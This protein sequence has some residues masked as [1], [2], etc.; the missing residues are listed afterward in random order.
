MKPLNDTTKGVV[1]GLGAYTLWG[2]WWVVIPY[3]IYAT[4]YATTSDSR[5]HETSHGTVFRTDWM[6]IALYELAS[7]M[8]MRESTVWRWP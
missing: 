8:V 4:L 1:Y 2:S 7:F 5:W 3:F 6:N